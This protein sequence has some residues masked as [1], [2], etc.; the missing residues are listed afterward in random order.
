M[1][2]LLACALFFP[3]WALAASAQGYQ[4][5]INVWV[6]EDA[7]D[8]PPSDA[9][10]FVGS[11]TIR[12]WE[13]LQ[14]D[15]AGWD[16]IQR[17]FGGSTMEDVNE[18]I[19]EIVLPYDPYAIVVYAGSSTLA[20]GATPQE[21]L[22]NYVT[23]V[24]TVHAGQNQSRPPIPIFLMSIVPAPARWAHWPKLEAFNEL[25]SD[26][27][28]SDP[29]LHFVDTSDEFLATGEPPA[30]E[31]FAPD[32]VHL[33]QLGYDVFT[34]VL[35]PELAATVPSPKVYHQN[36][37]ALGPGESLLFDFGLNTPPNSLPTT[38][39]DPNGN[40]S[41]NW[42]GTTQT[43][44]VGEHTGNLVST[45]GRATG[46][47]LVIAGGFQAGGSA[48]GGLLNPDPLLLG[49]FAVE[50]A[51]RDFFACINL[52]TPLT[53]GSEFDEVGYLVLNGLDRR[54]L[55]EVTLFG[56]RD[57]TSAQTTQYSCSGQPSCQRSGTVQTSGQ[58][59]GTL[60]EQND[61]TLVVLSRLRPNTY[62][63]LFIDIALADTGMAYLN[64]MEV[65]AS[66]PVQ[67][68]EQAFRLQP[69][70]RQ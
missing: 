47:G 70:L 56:S 43:V 31:L 42:P 32:G 37:L 4:S 33:S 61:D 66:L 35:L 67:P 13:R 6:A 38:S 62:G 17:G 57:G 41:N 7:L 54:W 2:G 68:P 64:A 14:K 28:D 60:G 9:V 12:K 44:L 18:F 8:P 45:T 69:S 55:Y 29:S 27:C 59:S 19:D 58:G 50:S 34:S 48:T 40:H 52:T 10:L 63:Q 26:Y 53:P 65:S 22:Q 36:P 51:T 21:E 3:C 1:K 11:S 30:A 15:F 25:L 46:I 23:F 39:P 16:V 49:E 24:D 20:S 5:Q